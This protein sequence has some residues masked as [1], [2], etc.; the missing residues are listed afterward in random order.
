MDLYSAVVMPLSQPAGVGSGAGGVGAGGVGDVLIFTRF[1]S[2]FLSVG[3]TTTGGKPGA[4][5]A[6]RS[7][8]RMCRGEKYGLVR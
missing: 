2:L 8:R 5:D 3:G 1:V 4:R 6:V 7:R